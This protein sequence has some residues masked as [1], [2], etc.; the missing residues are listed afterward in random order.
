MLRFPPVALA[1][2]TVSI[3]SHIAFSASFFQDL[4]GDV[5]AFIL[6]K[7]SRSRIRPILLF[8]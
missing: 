3:L 1:S 4:V 5:V 7:A 6:E 8:I 2:S